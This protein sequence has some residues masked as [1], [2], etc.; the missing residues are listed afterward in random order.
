DVAEMRRR[1]HGRKRIRMPTDLDDVAA[2]ENHPQGADVIAGG[3]MTEGVGAGRV[4]REHAADRAD[5]AAGGVRPGPAAF[6]GESGVESRERDARLDADPVGADV[7]DLSKG[8][9]EIDDDAATQRFASDAGAGS[10]RDEGNLV[11]EGVADELGE[12]G[13]VAR[14]D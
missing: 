8:T 11:L 9:R 3:A 13:L 2:V 6:L 4:G 12:I 7:D 10:A 5:V 1:V 14:D